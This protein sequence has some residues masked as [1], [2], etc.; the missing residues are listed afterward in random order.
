MAQTSKLPAVLQWTPIGRFIVFLLSAA[1]IWCL[2]AEFFH[3][4]TMRQF[5]IF[6]LIPATLVLIGMAVLD[7]FAGDGRLWRAVVFGSIGGLLAAF[8]YDIFRIPFVVAAVD[9]IGPNWLRLPLFKVF[10]RFGAMILGQPF[11]N[12]TTDTQF[13]M[14]THVIGWVYHFSNGMTF[15][16]MLLAIL[17]SVGKRVIL[18]AIVLAVGLELGMLFTPYMGYFGLGLTL[19]FFVA[20]MVAHLIFGIVLGVYLKSRAAVVNGFPLSHSGSLG[21]IGLAG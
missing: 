7:Y 21:G 20:T 11:D 6:A 3:L 15:G 2:L 9:H 4:C 19:K 17:G 5:T 1:S 8:S 16:V 18:A 14:L 10:P 12:N 13:P